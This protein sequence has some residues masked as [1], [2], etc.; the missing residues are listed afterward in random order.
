MFS[1]RRQQRKQTAFGISGVALTLFSV[2]VEGLGCAVSKLFFFLMNIASL[3]KSL[4]L[5]KLIQWNWGLIF[6]LCLVLVPQ[7]SA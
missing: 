6:Q 2:E 7:W 5:A 4:Y 3:G 1:L